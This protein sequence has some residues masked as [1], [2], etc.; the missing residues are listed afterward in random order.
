MLSNNEQNERKSRIAALSGTILVHAILLSV[1]L[2]LAFHTDMPLPPEEGVEINTEYNGIETS[3]PL[4]EALQP[5]L[6]DGPKTD[7]EKADENRDSE[8]GEETPVVK[9]K[10][11]DKPTS[12]KSKISIVE[13][14]DQSTL[15]NKMPGTGKNSKT[16]TYV[17]QGITEVPNHLG[18]QNE[19]KSQSA[20]ENSLEKGNGISFDLGGRGTRILPKPSFN[21]L[22]DGKIVVSV[23]VSNEGKVISATAGAKG[24]TITDPK[25]RKQ[26]ENAASMTLFAQD[27]NA[28]EQQRGTITYSIVKQK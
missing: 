5:A 16:V 8:L 1:L 20:K 9:K 14:P 25:L 17:N 13:T 22:E 19:T 11:T 6:N 3:N 24:T 21:S 26:A 27:A 7:Q 12:L 18:K 10:N 2:L 23:K 15:I 4:P 28:P